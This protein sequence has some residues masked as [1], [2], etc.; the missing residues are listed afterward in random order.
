[1]SHCTLS[2]YKTYTL[3]PHE[4]CPSFDLDILITR[5]TLLCHRDLPCNPLL[6]NLPEFT[7]TCLGP[8]NQRREGTKLDYHQLLSCFHPK[9]TFLACPLIT[10]HAIETMQFSCQM[11]QATRYSFTAWDGH[12]TKTLIGNSTPRYIEVMRNDVNRKQYTI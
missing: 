8:R 3:L 2:I 7:Y 10:P 5:Q 11:K 6:H 9:A 1:M 4:Q 12:T